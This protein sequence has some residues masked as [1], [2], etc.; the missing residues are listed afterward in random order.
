MTRLTRYGCMPSENARWDRYRVSVI[1]KCPVVGKQG[2]P[3]PL[4]RLR[5]S[6]KSSN[7]IRSRS[8][9]TGTVATTVLVAVLITETVFE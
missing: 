7:P 4:P 1:D 5:I 2:D 6:G 3:A 8:F 9:P